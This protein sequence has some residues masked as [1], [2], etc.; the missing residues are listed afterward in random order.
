[1]RE[2]IGKK[3]LILNVGTMMHFNGTFGRGN[4]AKFWIQNLVN[5]T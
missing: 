1:M 4:K 3:Y 2:T 5:T